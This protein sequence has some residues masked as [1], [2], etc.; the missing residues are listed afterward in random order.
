VTS[1][2]NAPS[3][4][5]H[6]RASRVLLISITLAVVVLVAFV[7]IAV[8][9][10]SRTSTTLGQDPSFSL[11]PYSPG[12]QHAPPPVTLQRL[13][14]GAPV[15][16]GGA[17]GKPLVVNFFASWCTACQKELGAV[18]SVARSGRVRFIGVDTDDDSPGQA[19]TLLHRAGA[20]YSVGVGNA[21]L[22]EEYGTANLPT[23]AFLDGRGRIVAL[24]L[25]A[26]TR[27]QLTRWVTRL[28]AGK[29]LT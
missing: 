27:K 20:T 13:G 4:S 5:A 7:A 19:L 15:V 26:L 3:A 6:R 12:K 24:A 17:T 9:I 25:G 28:A 16:V 8:R 14:G 11:V 22:A 18:A 21:S 2:T 1:A 23:T 29:P 10:A